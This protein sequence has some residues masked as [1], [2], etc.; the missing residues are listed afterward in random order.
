MDLERPFATLEL[1]DR[2]TLMLVD[3]VGF[4]PAEAAELVAIG[5]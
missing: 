2:E 4:S 3:S 5:C 1:A